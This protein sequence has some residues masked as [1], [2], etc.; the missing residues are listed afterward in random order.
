[1]SLV[2]CAFTL[3]EKYLANYADSYKVKTLKVKVGTQ[4]NEKL[5]KL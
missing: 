3:Y 4:G 1:M 5:V 2:P